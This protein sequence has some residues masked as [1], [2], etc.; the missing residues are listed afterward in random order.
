MVLYIAS[1]TET[2]GPSE[3][4]TLDLLDKNDKVLTVGGITGTVHNIWGRENKRIEKPEK[5]TAGN[6]SVPGCYLPTLLAYR[7]TLI[8][9]ST[10]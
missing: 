9:H 1:A 2:A 3:K 7:L 10:P 4:K 6:I 8:P 5:I